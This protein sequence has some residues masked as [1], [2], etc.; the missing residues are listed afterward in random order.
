MAPSPVEDILRQLGSDRPRD[1]WVQF[2][3]EY[4]P[5]LLQTIRHFERDPDHVSDCYLFVCQQ[6]CRDRFRRLRRF[7]VDGSARFS[8]WLRA[9]VRNLCLDWHRQAMGRGWIFDSVAALA[10]A[11]QEVFRLVFEQGAS[12]DEVF[13]RLSAR[14][15]GWTRPQLAES[16]ER[17]ASALT[18]RQR[19]LLSVRLGRFGEGR[20]PAKG[21]VEE[22]S[23]PVELL[24]D[25]VPSPESQA[26]RGQESKRLRQAMDRL[27]ADD[28]LLLQ[29]R[30]EQELTLEQVARIMG[31]ENAQAADRRIREVLKR[32]RTDVE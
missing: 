3:E 2:L 32:L 6:L 15:P 13:P 7:R 18:P 9:V 12:E 31:L 5:I 28:Q 8:T 10:P 21:D 29:M 16:V 1:A 20:G 30:F 17:I 19:W 23:H 26:M 24:P 22:D 27:A 11:D 4:S 14:F 25:G